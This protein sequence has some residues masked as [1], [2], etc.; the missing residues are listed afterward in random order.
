M[1]MKSLTMKVK[2]YA[3]LGCVLG[4]YTLYAQR[5]EP[6]VMATSGGSGSAGG[7]S[8]EWTL[9]Q[10]AMQTLK[11]GEYVLTQGFHQ[12]NL[13]VVGVRDVRYPFEVYIAPNPFSHRIHL[14]VPQSAL[15]WRAFTPDGKWV[16]DF[17][18]LHEEGIID[19][20]EAPQGTLLLQLKDKKGQMVSFQLIKL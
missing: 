6:Q 11:S 10:T 17:Q 9:G 12:P 3:F 20:Q 19:L 4:A 13:L 18:P 2:I 5:V 7:Y 8:L 1:G 15:W 16:T 14:Q